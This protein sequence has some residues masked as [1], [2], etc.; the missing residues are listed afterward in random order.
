VEKDPVTTVNLC[1]RVRLWVRLGVDE[2][3][4]H[5]LTLDQTFSKER[6]SA[7]LLLGNQEGIAGGLKHV[8]GFH[9]GDK[10]PGK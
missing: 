5:D 6:M 8:R 1:C 9:S 7:V 10:P 4:L 3:S 2:E